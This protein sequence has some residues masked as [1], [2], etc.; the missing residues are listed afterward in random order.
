MRLKKRYKICI[1]LLAI[2]VISIFV[3]GVND[4]SAEING[5]YVAN[6]TVDSEGL[7]DA[8][9]N[10]QLLNLLGRLVYA[11]GRLL[12]WILGTIFETITNG[13]AD[14]PW[15][16]KIVFNAVPLL[17]VNFI[18]PNNNSYLGNSAVKGAISKT[19]ATV[20][21]ISLSFFTI[22][23]MISAIKLAI[24]TIADQKAKYKKA[25]IDWSLGLI[26]LF[27]MHY[28]ISFIFYLNEQLV[29]TAQKIFSDTLDA[30]SVKVEMQSSVLTEELLDSIKAMG[31]P[32]DGY[33]DYLEEN[34]NVVAAWITL[35]SST[36]N[37]G[38]H[39]FAMN[40]RKLLWTS[41][42][43]S[44]NDDKKVAEN[45]YWVVK[46][47]NED[48]PDLDKLNEVKKKVF[49]VKMDISVSGSITVPM[50]VSGIV[51]NTYN[52]NGLNIEKLINKLKD[53]PTITSKLANVYGQIYK[54]KN[55]IAEVNVQDA[56]TKYGVYFSP[57]ASTI[58]TAT[59]TP[60]PESWN[61][62]NVISNIIS[63]KTAALNASSSSSGRYYSGC[64]N[65]RSSYIF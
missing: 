11:T 2:L 31:S 14:F 30:A 8:M 34:R 19:Y 15:A 5:G 63:L 18:N 59:D 24:S 52:N 4:V 1:L 16:D 36:S 33:A 7:N 54:N 60:N 25:L 61:W 12:E 46:W 17:D 35:D 38:M 65:N 55:L 28:F 42:L 20:F 45:L 51:Q 10:S 50:G 23:V 13:K 44:S 22:F 58:K 64:Y 47:I 57:A 9:K 21:S 43:T 26:M 40:N 62:N 32:Y 27:T 29:E 41:L 39:Q 37:T 6:Y 56:K 3:R 49:Y 53:P 48:C